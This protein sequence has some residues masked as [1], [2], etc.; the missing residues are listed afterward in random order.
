MKGS[1][2]ESIEM[3]MVNGVKGSA[4]KVAGMY[5]VDNRIILRAGTAYPGSDIQTQRPHDL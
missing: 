3:A 2:L 5:N 4:V 1:S